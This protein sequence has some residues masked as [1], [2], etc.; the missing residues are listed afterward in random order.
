[1]V[2]G[3]QDVL[4]VLLRG[5]CPA[6]GQR[7]ARP[8]RPRR[9]PR[10]RVRAR[11]GG[12]GGGDPGRGREG[13]RPS[14]RRGGGRPDEAGAAGPARVR[15]GGPLQADPAARR[16]SPGPADPA[17]PER[18][19]V[20]GSGAARS[21]DDHISPLACRPMEADRTPVAMTIAT[22]DSGGGA[23]IQADLKAFARCGVH[24]TSAIVALTAQNTREVVSVAHTAARS[25]S[26]DQVRA[27]ADGHRR[28]RGQGRDARSTS[29]RSRRWRR[30]ARAS[31]ACPWWWT[32]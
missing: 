32:R 31:A 10:A 15:L 1:M 9:C 13:R 3:G 22:S 12:P 17:C 8:R 30:A 25:S 21:V 26:V 5:R 2:R 11:R 19:R 20:M 7:G 16:S 6:A 4:D 18:L 29:R 24:G 23:G 27:V 14:P 28:G